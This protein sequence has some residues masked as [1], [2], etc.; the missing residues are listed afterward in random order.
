MDIIKSQMVELD[1]PLIGQETWLSLN[2]LLKIVAL[3]VSMF[4][5]ANRKIAFGLTLQ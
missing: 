4:V 3:Q 2:C 1:V 5:D